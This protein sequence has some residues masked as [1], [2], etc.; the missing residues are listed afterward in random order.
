MAEVSLDTK[1]ETRM[2]V[3]TNRLFA[4]AQEQEDKHNIAM[5]YVLSEI[6]DGI[7]QAMSD[8]RHKD[9]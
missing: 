9:D 8:E 4:L 5:Y 3:Y 6:C 1:L 2:M 7:K